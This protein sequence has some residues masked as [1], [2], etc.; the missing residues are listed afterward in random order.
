MEENE[1]VTEYPVDDMD[2]GLVWGMCDDD[3][4]VASTQIC[5]DGL[6]TIHG[7]GEMDEYD[8]IPGTAGMKDYDVSPWTGSDITVAV[9][10]KGVTSVGRA[11]FYN[12][13]ELTAVVIPESVTRIGAF[14]FAGCTGLKSVVIPNSVVSIG[15]GAFSYCENLKS[16][17]IG[18][19]IT[20]IAKWA[21]NPCKNL[22]TIVIQKAVPPDVQ[23]ES[24]AWSRLNKAAVNAA[25]LYVPQAG[26]AAYREN[27]CWKCFYNHIIEDV[28]T[29][30][31]KRKL[32]EER[33]RALDEAVKSLDL[34]VIMKK[35]RERFENCDLSDNFFILPN[36]KVVGSKES[37]ADMIAVTAENDPIL[38]S[39]F[40][41]SSVSSRLM[42]R[43]MEDGGVIRVESGISESE[44]DDTVEIAKRPSL[45]QMNA[46]QR[47]VDTKREKGSEYEL[48]VEIGTRY[49][50]FE[51]P[52]DWDEVLEFILVHTQLE[53]LSKK[54]ETEDN[55]GN[56]IKYDIWED[57]DL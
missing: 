37:H 33:R 50:C 16:V 14:A 15:K 31:E 49:I 57:E 11:A 19:G 45:Q 20:S 43:L 44:S 5:N 7:R 38:E 25:H 41:K 54:G 27:I 55:D 17:V 13:T 4:H 34:N 46:L 28:E 30:I 1:E 36:G 26:I 21:F 8:I 6:L 39:G 2:L 24:F 32:E 53:H 23:Y 12:C 3:C 22:S 56:I 51:N 9:I 42:R 48:V 47:F 35:L 52:I 18:S 29:W 10:E 40:K